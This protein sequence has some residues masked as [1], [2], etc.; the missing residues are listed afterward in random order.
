MPRVTV[1]GYH[2]I[3]SPP[4]GRRAT[5]YTPEGAFVGHLNYLRENGWRVVDLAWFLDRLETL[6]TVSERL[7]LLTF[8]DAYRSVRDIA[9]PRLAE[10]GYPAVVFVPTQFIDGQN[11]FD[12]GEEP[13]EDICTWEDL[14]E[15]TRSGVSVQS[16]GVSHRALQ[17]LRYAEL[18][19]EV[20]KSKD[21][22]EAG[23]GIRVEAFAYPFGDDG[24]NPEQTKELLRK[25]GYRAAFL[26]RGGSLNTLVDPYRLNRLPIRPETDLR[27]ELR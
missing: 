7:A 12:R 2:K 9:L 6:G 25:S 21:V 8:D 19:E 18:R 14:A 11:D 16:H 24:R 23:L 10:F 5:W 1:L 26:A 3:G 27:I 20:A 17:T 13:V 4:P 15:L 22:L